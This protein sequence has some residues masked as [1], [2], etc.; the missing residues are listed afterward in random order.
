MKELKWIEVKQL[1][2]VTQLVKQ[3]SCD[4]NPYL[5]HSEIHCSK[6]TCFAQ[7]GPQEHSIEVTQKL[8]GA[9]SQTEPRP[10]KSGPSVQLSLRSFHPDQG[11][12]VPV[13]LT[14]EPG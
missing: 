2:K 7:C 12:S 14:L 5:S 11:F 1:A 13:L 8:V 6:N 4:S 9:E 10:T 3:Q